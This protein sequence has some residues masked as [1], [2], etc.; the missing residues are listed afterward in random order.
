MSDGATDGD[1]ITREELH[2]RAISFRSWR[3]SDGLFEILGNV[4]DTKTHTFTPPAE[5]RTVPP[6]EPIHEMY[7]KLVFDLDMRIHAVDTDIRAFPY[8]QCPGGGATLQG[9]VGASMARGWNNVLRERLDR[10][11]TCTHLRELLT[12]LASAAFQA[13]SAFRFDRIIAA[14]EGGRPVHIDTCY[15]Y[16]AS[17]DRVRKLWPK[18]HRP[19][20]EN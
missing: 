16:N 6:G 4:T 8:A 10:S 3:R 2:T 18:F 19:A 17:R 14:E 12:P 7:V 9:L 15:A 13:V 1:A 5:T 11:E 20:G